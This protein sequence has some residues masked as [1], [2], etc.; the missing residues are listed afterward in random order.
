MGVLHEA[1]I[2]A[3]H[4]MAAS[5]GARQSLTN[6]L[7]ASAL[8]LIGRTTEAKKALGQY[9]A[10]SAIKTTTIV[11]LRMQRF[12]LADNPEWIAY[13]ERLFD[14]LGMPENRARWARR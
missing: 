11:Q 10:Y 4:R 8:V 7:R 1:A 6:L 2:R 13:N 3:G 14:G 12:A 9:R 5:G